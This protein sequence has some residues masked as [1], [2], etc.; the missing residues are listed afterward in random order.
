MQ[1][2]MQ[3]ASDPSAA[4][5]VFQ[6]SSPGD[7][8]CSLEDDAAPGLMSDSDDDD[9]VDKTGEPVTG[10]EVLTRHELEADPFD[11]YDFDV[12][13]YEP[14]EFEVHPRAEYQQWTAD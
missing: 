11:G 7:N 10:H 14:L 5:C 6:T 3:A 8:Y 9:D 1:D 13:N 2:D 4:E 12:R